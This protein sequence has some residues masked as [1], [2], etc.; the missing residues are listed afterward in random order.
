MA[1]RLL[2]QSQARLGLRGPDS[3]SSSES[4]I[5][6]RQASK[7]RDVNMEFIED[8]PWDEDSCPRNTLERMYRDVITH[9]IR[10]VGCGNER[11]RSEVFRWL[12]KNSFCV[13]CEIASWSE[14]WVKELLKS[15]DSMPDSVR[16]DITKS[17]MEMLKAISRVTPSDNNGGIMDNMVGWSEE[18]DIL[19]EQTY[20]RRPL[21]RSAY[22]NRNVNFDAVQRGGK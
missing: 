6:E 16:K 19:N 8:E 5:Q 1:G 18:K 7:A 15:I 12:N 21:T 14:D 22:N 11:E 20:D 3:G 10:D 13:C 4:Y 17:C 2:C 9:A